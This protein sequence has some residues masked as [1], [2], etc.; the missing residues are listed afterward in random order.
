MKS[1]E[2]SASLTIHA[3]ETDLVLDLKKLNDKISGA[4]LRRK[5]GKFVLVLKKVEEFKWYDLLSKAD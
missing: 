4:E 1:A 5:P 3:G 2:K